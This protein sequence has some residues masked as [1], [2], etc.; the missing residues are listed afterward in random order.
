MAIP[1]PNKRPTVKT[2]YESPA[3]YGPPAPSETTVPAPPQMISPKSVTINGPSS[4]QESVQAWINNPNSGQ[5]GMDTYTKVQNQRWQTAN[6]N[7]DYDSMKKLQS[8]A[9]RVGYTLNPYNPPKPNT[10]A[11]TQFADWQAKQGELMQRY[12][13][14]LNTPFQY[15]PETDPGYQAQRQLAQLRA[16]DASRNAMET[17]NDR[18][19]LNSSITGSQLG[20]IQQRAEQ[21]AAAFIPQYRDQ[22]RQDYQERL[23]NAA[24]MLNFAAGRGDAAADMAYRDKRADRS[25]MESDRAFDRGA[26]ESDRNFDRGALES[27]RAFDYQ[28]GRDKVGDQRYDQ[29]FAYQQARD[30]IKDEQ[31]KLQFDEDVRRHGLDYAL[32]Q[33]AQDNQFANAAADNARANAQL[34][35]Q[36][37][38][39]DFDKEQANKPKDSKPTQT[40]QNNEIYAEVLN[41]L[42]QMS[43]Q[44]RTAFFKGEK[45]SIVK[46]LGI[47]GYNKL[48]RQYFDEYGDPTQ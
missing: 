14:M 24:S 33:A 12:E 23:R 35:L 41:E 7:N 32:R 13:Q 9:Q 4:E 48:Y 22:A 31:Y 45:N 29:E 20:Q 26:M 1:D 11:P 21:E 6:Q 47:D 46:D 3:P 27:D 16:G 25:D 42:D 43:P 10:S 19:I 39:F 28:V 44:E 38:R 15:N 34:D 2:S 5:G 30:Q 40:E 37:Q 18:G 8:D 36:R 17:L